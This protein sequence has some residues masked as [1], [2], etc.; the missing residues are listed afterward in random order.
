MT[1][2]D[3]SRIKISDTHPAMYRTIRS[4][5]IL[6][7]CLAINFWVWTPA[8]KPFNI[9]NELV[10]VIFFVLG[11]SQLIFLIFVPNLLMTRRL[12]GGFVFFNLVWGVLNA[13]QWYDGPAS[14]QLPLYIVGLAVVI[15]PWITE[16][17][18][19]P[20]TEKNGK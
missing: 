13:Q 6:N 19:N 1:A 17:A 4:V 12:L 20:M 9:P 7:V 2:P 11:V 16:P 15:R 10:G 18:V 8:F 3:H 14:L 5:S